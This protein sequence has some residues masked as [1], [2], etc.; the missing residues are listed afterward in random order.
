LAGTQERLNEKEKQLLGCMTQLDEERNKKE[1]VEKAWYSR[2]ENQ[3]AEL[4]QMEEMMIQNQS[5]V[6]HLNGLLNQ[7]HMEIEQLRDSEDEQRDVLA[8]FEKQKRLLESEC[9][10][11]RCH[12]ESVTKEREQLKKAEATLQVSIQDISE[13]RYYLTDRISKLE[14]ELNQVKEELKQ[15]SESDQIEKE[16]LRRALESYASAMSK[17]GAELQQEIEQK[18]QSRNELM[19]EKAFREQLELE[20]QQER[21]E[22]KMMEDANGRMLIGLLDDL[23][24]QKEEMEALR[25]KID[26]E[27]DLRQKAEIALR[28]LEYIF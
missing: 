16:E 28:Q 2:S 4:K 5:E 22:K 14:I 26:V 19:L 18:N 13:E 15:Q 25:Q 23:K 27:T 12:L 1:Q 21:A 20:L 17:L 10:D 24:K 11:L 8:T 3:T 9:E 6:S 7:S